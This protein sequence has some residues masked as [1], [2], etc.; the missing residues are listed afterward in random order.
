MRFRRTY[1][2]P[3][4]EGL[5][6]MEERGMVLFP[7]PQSRYHENSHQPTSL[8]SWEM[9]GWHKLH[10]T[11]MC[12]QK[13]TLT[14]RCDTCYSWAK[15]PSPGPRNSNPSTP[16]LLLANPPHS[17]WV[18]KRESRAFSKHSCVAH[19][20]KAQPMQHASSLQQF[21]YW[22]GLG[23]DSHLNILSLSRGKGL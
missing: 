23:L 9:N 10:K 15:Q 5:G 17:P 1:A 21:K 18:Y 16:S 20:K 4:K 12:P 13:D 22:Q 2:H 11:H 19:P 6:K 3:T 14:H 7:L 8:W